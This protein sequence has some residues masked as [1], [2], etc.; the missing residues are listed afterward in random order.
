M[1]NG[2][3]DLVKYLSFLTSEWQRAKQHRRPMNV[4]EAKKSLGFDGSSSTRPVLTA[5]KQEQAVLVTYT[6]II[7]STL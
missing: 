7:L 4:T 5:C 3:I 1:S 2:I 6:D